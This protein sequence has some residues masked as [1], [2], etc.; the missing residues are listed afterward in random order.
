M[1]ELYKD[2]DIAKD[3]KRRTLQWAGHVVRM[4]EERIP[5]KVTMGRFEGV[6]PICRPR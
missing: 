6:T 3:V 2:I 4:P 5:R 1:Y